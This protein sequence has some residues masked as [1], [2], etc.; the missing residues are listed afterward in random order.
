MQ[1]NGGRTKKNWR[2]LR[3]IKRLREIKWVQLWLKQAL[4]G[5]FVVLV[6]FQ[7]RVAWGATV[8]ATGTF[9]R[10]VLTPE[11]LQE[12]LRSPI[13][14]EGIRTVD[15][16]RLVIDLR[17][18]NANF[19]DQFYR[20]LQAQLQ[21]S[22]G[23]PGLDLSNSLIKGDFE[24]AQLG[25]RAPLSGQALSP[26]FTPAERQQL[27]RDRRRLFRLRQLS[28]SLLS[29]DLAS[30]ELQLR[31]FR[32][33]LKLVQT[34]FS[35]RVNFSNTFFLAPVASQSATFAQTAD[36]S[37]ARFSV[38][39]SFASATFA[40]AAEFYNSIF[41]AKAS[42][43]Q[44]RFLNLTH[45]QKS[46]FQT[47]AN[48]NQARFQQLANF[49]RVE[50]QG[51]ADFAQTN[52]QQALF[53]QSKFNQA[54]FVA[55]AIFD[56]PVTF[57][58]TEF[59]RPVN[60]RGAAILAQADFSDARFT[61]SA[62]LN[63]PGLQFDPKQVRILGN[64]GQIG[65]VFSVPTLQGNENLLRNLVRNF[66]D[67]E[68]IGDANQVEYTTQKLRLRWFRQQLLN[69]NVNQASPSRLAE[70]GF[71]PAQVAAIA[72]ARLEQPLRSLSELLSRE[73]VDLATY[74][75]LRDRVI[76]GEPLSLGSW[77]LTALNWLGLSLLL[78]LSRY[79]SSFWLT[80]GVG[81]VA[82][83]VFGLLFWLV[84]RWRRLRPYPVIPNWSETIWVLLN[85][86]LLSVSGLIAIFHTTDTPWLTLAFLAG[87]TLPLPVSLLWLIYQR[88]RYHD[89][90][91]VSY[92]VEDG[93][94]RQLRLLI[95]RLPIMPRFPFFRERYEPI[96]WNRRWSWLNYYDLSLN[97]F[98]KFGFNDIRLRDEHLPGLISSLVWYQW[99]LGILYIILLL[100]TLSRTI[101]GL[102]LFIYF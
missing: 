6:F 43:N 1:K 93:S 61:S 36:W 22:G 47:T 37:G 56:K 95:G 34:Y 27:S 97:N 21:R 78:L 28:R 66:R 23:S 72:Q 65:Q 8:A 41:F 102:N 79:G 14:A 3:Q 46:E 92:F 49:S 51:N 71:T 17:P 87:L 44:V 62:Y 86:G 54:L 9:Q 38:P 68:Q 42:F 29:N 59:S 75:R 76:A 88:G 53:T 100:W 32:G 94:L 2:R 67:L 60:F 45:F 70:I 57:R 50:W 89:L 15:L 13:S 81:L 77:V 55:E 20:N 82:I 10:Q 7:P 11:L 35:G 25:L 39:V 91:E 24:G 74:T 80:F 58:E 4:L 83:A 18:E 30:R 85:F 63:V 64:P 48:F 69:P 19:R 52:W 96:L 84:D 40:Q 98:L 12:R 5:I 101:P 73:I 31:V 99:G 16:R 26:I 90:M 33:P